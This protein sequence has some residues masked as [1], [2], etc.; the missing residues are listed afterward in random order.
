LQ[1]AIVTTHLNTFGY[2]ALL[3]AQLSQQNPAKVRSPGNSCALRKA[4]VKSALGFAKRSLWIGAFP[5]HIC[6]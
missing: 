6:E 5:V 4:K 3:H 1:A 2:L